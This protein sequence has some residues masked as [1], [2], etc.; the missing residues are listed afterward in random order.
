MKH[1]THVAQR[2]ALPVALVGL[3]QLAVNAGWVNT[4]FVPP[5]A[6]VLEAGYDGFT[7]NGLLQATAS[8]TG[9]ALLGLAI[10]AAVAIPAGLLFAISELV[11][12]L[13]SPVREFFRSLPTVTVIPALMVVVGPGD[14]LTLLAVA[15]GAVWPVLL[16]TMLGVRQTDQTL[17]DVA[18]VHRL[19]AWDSVFRVRLPAA[20]PQ[21]M[22]GL[23]ISLAIALVIALVVEMMSGHGGLGSLVV[24]ARSRFRNADVFAIVAVIGV[25]GLALNA[26]MVR[27]ERRSQRAR[28]V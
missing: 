13:T 17:L 16:G 5:P 28:V 24:E 18:K 9:R 10:A 1:A 27:V 26:L 15:F 8:T 7:E 6:D 21:I 19:S 11:D 3:W 12:S 22:T 2:L 25:V 20:L 23:R 14:S 4:V